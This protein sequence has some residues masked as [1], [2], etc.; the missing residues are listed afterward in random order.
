MEKILKQKED[1]IAKGAKNY[2][3]KYTDTF[4]SSDKKTLKDNLLPLFSNGQE[5]LKLHV[6]EPYPKYE[7]KKP[8][9]W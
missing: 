8:E 7:D 3:K 4:A 5:E 1:E 6:K 9:I 2:F